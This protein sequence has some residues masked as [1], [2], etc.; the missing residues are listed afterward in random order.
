[1]LT[2]LLS[3]SYST[4]F[5]TPTRTHPETTPLTVGWAPLTSLIKKEYAHRLAY[6]PI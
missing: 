2:G 4:Y 5:L 6:K 3:K 1:M